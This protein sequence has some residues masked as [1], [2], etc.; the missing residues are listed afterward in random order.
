M[1]SVNGVE[2]RRKDREVTDPA[3]IERILDLCKTCF[4]AL[5]TGGAPYVVPLSYGYAL[6]DG[7]LTLYFHCAS[8]GRKLDLLQ[9][10]ARVGFAL[11]KEGRLLTPETPCHSGM[12]Y[13]SVVGEGVAAIVTDP[14]EKRDALA[15]MFLRQTGRRV[16]FT[17]EQAAGVCVVKVTATRYSAKARGEMV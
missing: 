13:V 1:R 14:C 11:A 2:M 4:I 12:E 10:D 8:E 3:R 16:C 7:T 6:A 17:D 15:R 5:N 9:S